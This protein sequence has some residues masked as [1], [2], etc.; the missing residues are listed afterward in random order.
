MAFAR[1]LTNPIIADATTAVTINAYSQG[2]R[3]WR[4]GCDLKYSVK[5]L[6]QASATTRVNA[7][8]KESKYIDTTSLFVMSTIYIYI[9]YI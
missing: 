8:V 9:L 1:N 2:P 3:A 6:F 4:L 7:L 5:A